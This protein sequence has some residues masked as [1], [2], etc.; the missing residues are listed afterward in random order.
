MMNGAGGGIGNKNFE[1][2]EGDIRQGW[3]QRVGLET[4]GE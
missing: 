1:K 4:A 3:R 2:E